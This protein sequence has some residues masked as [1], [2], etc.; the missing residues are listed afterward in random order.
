[1][2]NVSKTGP[3]SEPEKGPG[4]Q[5]T[6]QPQLNRSSKCDVISIIIIKLIKLK[7]SILQETHIMH[8]QPSH[9]DWELKWRQFS[10]LSLHKSFTKQSSV[11]EASCEMCWYAMGPTDS[12]WAFAN[13]AGKIIFLLMSTNFLNRLG[14]QNRNGSTDSQV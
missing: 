10:K 9:I 4:G 14:H 5:V 7:C 12:W 13:N 2:G 3:M 1:M 8:F 6:I 11:W